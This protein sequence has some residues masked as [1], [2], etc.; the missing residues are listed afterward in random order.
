M[1]SRS[2]LW[3][4][5]AL[6]GALLVAY[7]PSWTGLALHEWL[8]AAAIAPL[9]FHLAINW[10]HAMAI[11]RRFAEH[12]RHTP[13]LNLVVDSALFVSAVGVTL[14]GF[15]VSRAIA[16]ALGLVFAPSALWTS[17]H[18]FTADT[19]IA[20]LVVHFGLHWKWIA[21]VARRMARPSVP[22]ARTQETL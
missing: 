1:T 15:M 14:S 3:L 10:E 19:T 12:V 17:V 22:S 9:L 7:N 5:L 4:D 20:L 6:F 21:G 2:R 8:C 11:A 18:S 16:G 13:R